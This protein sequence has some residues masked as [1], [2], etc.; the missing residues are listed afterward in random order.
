MRALLLISAALSLGGCAASYHEPSLPEDHPA[1][2]TATSAATPEPSRTLI[3]TEQSAAPP[4]TPGGVHRGHGASP[5]DAS[6]QQPAVHEH[7]AAT[8]S[9]PSDPSEPAALH[10]C[11]MH[12]EVTSDK[13]DQRCPRC[14]MKL[15]KKESG[16]QP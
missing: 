16:T 6:P 5:N 3:V 12:P 14:G 10:V 1:N 4:R 13:P 9:D 7:P 15:V 8:P 2:P 11:P